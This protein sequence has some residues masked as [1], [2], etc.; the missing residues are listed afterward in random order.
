[1]C[2][3]ETISCTPDP[4]ALEGYE[5]FIEA[6]IASFTRLVIDPDFRRLGLPKP[7]REVRLRVAAERG[8]RSIVA[9]AEEESVMIA[10]EARG[11]IRL[12]PTRIRYLSYAPSI[13]LLKRLDGTRVV[14]DFTSLQMR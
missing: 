11:F 10:L 6:P 14:E 13:V 4:E 3:H 2:I 7:L 12:G 8:C 9:V 1:M 5:H